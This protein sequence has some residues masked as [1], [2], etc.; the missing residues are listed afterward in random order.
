MPVSEKQA[1][2][3]PSLPPG[4]LEGAHG[5]AV[6]GGD[7]IAGPGRP[8]LVSVVIP[9]YNR[10]Y[11][12]ANTIESVLGQ[13][14][15][16][17]EV[18]VID[19]GSTD[20]TEDI[21]AKFPTKVHYI[22]QPNAGV[23]AARNTGFRTAQGEFV[24]LLDSDDVWLPWK[25]AG[26]V[27]VLRA[28]PDVG[29]VWTDMTAVDHTGRELQKCYLRTFY[30]AYR[31]VKIEEV[32]ADKSTL[33]SLWPQAQQLPQLS[34]AKVYAGDLFSHMILG[35]MV[36]TSTVLLRRSRLQAVGP[37]DVGLKHSGEDYEFHLRTAYNG[38]VAL[39]DAPCI[40][41]RVGA[42]D[43]L[44][45]PQYMIHIAR[46]NLATVRRWTKPG[47]RQ[48]SLPADVLNRRIAGAY[49]WLGSCERELGQT[50]AAFKHLGL[51]FLMEPSMG[52]LRELAVNCLPQ[53][54]QELAR[55]AKRRLGKT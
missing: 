28:L 19:D 22:R 41:Y 31:Q 53:R 10:G 50:G 40:L 38:P 47:S 39:I 43:Q 2:A 49:A 42:E 35:N 18:I 13:S 9:T 34:G 7:F 15:D 12:I 27:A 48:I 55:S 20:D 6:Q 25:L 17:V 52:T 5:P 36:H 26:Q 23:C 44:T 30:D 16:N 33:P 37:F 54:A 14:Y 21:V 11:I 46:N 24:A 8:G 1:A 32:L 29:M 45:Q 51:S 3:T 4:T